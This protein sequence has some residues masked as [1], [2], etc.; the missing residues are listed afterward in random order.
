MADSFEESQGPRSRTLHFS[1]VNLMTLS[2]YYIKEMTSSYCYCW[3]IRLKEAKDVE[4]E[5]QEEQTQVPVIDT[6]DQHRAHLFDLNCKVCTGKMVPGS[7]EQATAAVS[8]KVFKRYFGISDMGMLSSCFVV[9]F[10]DK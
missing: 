10:S 1:H 5:P 6:T 2:Q 8:V 4:P 3:Q 7:E 9:D